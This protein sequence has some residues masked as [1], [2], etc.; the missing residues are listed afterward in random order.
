M[1]NENASR[2]RDQRGESL[3]KL[4]SA[5]QASRRNKRACPRPGPLIPRPIAY[6][7]NLFYDSVAST[8]ALPM[9][10]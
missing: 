7:A 5:V 3:A 6:S 10:E 9:A 2:V 1:A 8:A 4:G